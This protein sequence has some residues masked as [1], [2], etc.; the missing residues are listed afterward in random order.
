MS[1]GKNNRRKGTKKKTKAEISG[2][3]RNLNTRWGPGF[4]DMPI[5]PRAHLAE[6]HPSHLTLSMTFLRSSKTREL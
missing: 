6:V 4:S 5:H 2:L 1:C 3:K